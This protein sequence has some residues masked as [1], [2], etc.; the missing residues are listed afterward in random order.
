MNPNEVLDNCLNIANG[1]LAI[2]FLPDPK[3]QVEVEFICRCNTNKAPI[4]FLL[5]CLLA[6]I[7]CPEIDIRKPYT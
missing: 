3:V 6:K 7:D 5:A 2:S 1:S 4:R